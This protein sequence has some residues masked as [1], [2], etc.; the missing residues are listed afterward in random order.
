MGMTAGPMPP[1]P[2]AG[3]TIADFVTRLI[4]FVID[5]IIL[6]VVN[7]VVY[8]VLAAVLLFS[9]GGLLVV[10]HAIIVLGISAGYFIYFWTMRQQTPGMIVMKLKVVEDGTG[11]TLTQSKAIRRW[12][13]LG[14]PLALSSLLSIGGGLG[15]FALGGLGGLFILFT[16]ATIVGIA[17]LAWEIYLAYTTYQDPR[18]Q[19]VHD[20]AVNSV[21]V[22]YG[23]SPLGGTR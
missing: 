11:A 19:G 18:K 9:L 6:A 22:S 10:V 15:G 4:A 16:L 21:V 3:T 7:F 5:A 20:K 2:I 17:G 14:L 8:T 1:G 23:P 12:M 13:F